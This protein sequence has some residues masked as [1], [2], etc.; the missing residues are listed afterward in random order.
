M[1]Y[2]K[3]LSATTGVVAIAGL[4]IGYGWAIFWA[5]V[6]TVGLIAAIRIYFRRNK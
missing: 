1:D 3:T 6:A 4:S 2:G 5:L